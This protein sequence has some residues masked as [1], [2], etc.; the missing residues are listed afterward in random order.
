[1]KAKLRHTQIKETEG[2]LSTVHLSYKNGER[3]SPGYNERTLDSIQRN[4]EQ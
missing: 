4:K 3:T 2:S 1:M